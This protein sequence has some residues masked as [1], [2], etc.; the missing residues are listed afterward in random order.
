MAEN[1]LLVGPFLGACSVR[2]SDREYFQDEL[3]A[4]IR[5]DRGYD[6][7]PYYPIRLDTTQY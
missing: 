5:H 2:K 6:L 4:R 1:K 7:I 3:R